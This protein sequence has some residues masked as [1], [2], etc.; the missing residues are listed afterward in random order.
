MK[1]I[2][3][4]A[5]FGLLSVVDFTYSQNIPSIPNFPPG[6]QNLLQQIPAPILT[7]MT[8][9]QTD[10]KSMKSSGKINDSVLLA[11]MKAVADAAKANMNNSSTQVQAQI[12]QMQTAIKDMQAA[13]KIDPAK[14]QTVAQSFASAIN[15]PAGMPMFDQLLKNVQGKFKRPTTTVKPAK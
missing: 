3:S 2:L 7:A 12:T 6:I 1:T 4:I 14:L 13:G 11:D 10:I 15:L 8:K 9:V 5:I